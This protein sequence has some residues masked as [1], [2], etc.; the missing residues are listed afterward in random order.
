MPAR[1]KPVQPSSS[2]RFSKRFPMPAELVEAVKAL[3]I[4]IADWKTLFEQQKEFTEQARAELAASQ[5][6]HLAAIQE[7]SESLSKMRAHQNEMAKGYR[8]LLDKSDAI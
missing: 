4:Q 1:P 8:G 3:G 6:A 5:A 7:H 2:W